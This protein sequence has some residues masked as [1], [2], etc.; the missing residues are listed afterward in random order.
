M[1]QENQSDRVAESELLENS[2]KATENSEAKRYLKVPPAQDRFLEDSHQSHRSAVAASKTE[3]S[4][5]D[6]P[7]LCPPTEDITRD[8]PYRK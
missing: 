6:S 7:F 1:S 5:K 2:H 3:G 8:N 4:K